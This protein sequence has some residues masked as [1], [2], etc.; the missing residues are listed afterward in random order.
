MLTFSHRK[1][2]TSTNFWSK[3]VQNLQQGTDAL[4]ICYDI[5]PNT[6]QFVKDKWATLVQAHLTWFPMI[7]VYSFQS[8][9][10]LR[11]GTSKNLGKSKF[12]LII[13]LIRRNKHFFNGIH[14]LSEWWK[15][16]WLQM[17]N[18]QKLQCSSGHV[19]VTS[20]RYSSIKQELVGHRLRMGD[21]SVVG[22]AMQRDPLDQYGQQVG[23]PRTT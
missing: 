4:M 17:R 9:L 15:N 13:G 21:N 22:C 7:V 18:I 16:F 3:N 19:Y 23:C 5:T 6:A 8:N 20:S 11:I 1:L 2:L 14:K 12:G 10:R